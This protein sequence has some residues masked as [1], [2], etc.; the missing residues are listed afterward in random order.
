MIPLPQIS[1]LPL[2]QILLANVGPMRHAGPMLAND[3]Y[4][5]PMMV[6]KAYVELMLV[7]VEPSKH[8][9]LLSK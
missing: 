4:I 6:N 2:P 7:N 5:R 3:V 8:N 9:T 1:T